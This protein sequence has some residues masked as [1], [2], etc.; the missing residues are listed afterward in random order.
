MMRRYEVAPDS[1]ASTVN[2]SKRRQ[3]IALALR[4]S[5]IG[6]LAS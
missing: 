6:N 3:R 2:S 1:S 4:A 5:W